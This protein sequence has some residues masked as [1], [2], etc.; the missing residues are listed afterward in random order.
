MNFL[1][2]IIKQSSLSSILFFIMLSAGPAL[3]WLFI[4]L[5][6]DRKQP[7]PKKQIIKTFFIGMVATIPLLFIAGFLSSFVKAINLS[8]LLSILALSF[9][10]YGLVEE[11][12]KY[13]ILR[14]SV[15]KF[16]YFDELRD[17]LIYGMVL[18][19]GLAFIENILYGLVAGVAKGAS[20]VLLRGFSTTLLHFLTGGII[21]Y[22]ITL[23]VVSP[24]KR[25]K[26]MSYLG[27]LIAILAHGGYNVV[28][29][30][31]LTWPIMGP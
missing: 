19:L 2:N 22:F 4:C 10:I 16:H 24:Y 29:R 1:I 14:V 5:W 13:I 15:V 17:G 7:E 27:F 8:T 30:L 20:L 11:L 12:A 23:A 6:L 9:L 21:G 26:Y 28:T 25:G 3:I 18:G 31:G